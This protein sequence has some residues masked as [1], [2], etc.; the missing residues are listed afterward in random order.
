MNRGN[1]VGIE[2]GRETATKRGKVGQRR[3][4]E[5]VRERARERID[6]E[7]HAMSS[8]ASRQRSWI[9]AKQMHRGV[10][11]R[12]SRCVSAESASAMP[13]FN[14]SVHLLCLYPTPLQQMQILR[15]RYATTYHRQGAQQ[16]LGDIYIE[17]E[18]GERERV[19]RDSRRTYIRGTSL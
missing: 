1:A 5:T 11:T 14:A 12:H 4:R 10:E 3:E 2:R 18:R 7:N 15:I 16:M 19:M 9:Q 8:M 17:R 13:L 6:K